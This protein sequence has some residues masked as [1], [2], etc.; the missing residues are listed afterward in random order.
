MA[1]RFDDFIEKIPKNIHNNTRTFIGE[2]I[3][4]FIPDTYVFNKPLVNKD[5][6][7]VIFHSSPP[8]AIVNNKEYQFKNGTLLCMSPGTEI[9]VKFIKGKVPA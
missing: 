6:H 1:N 5:Y 3:A 7:F 9:T 2:N 8:L 4:V